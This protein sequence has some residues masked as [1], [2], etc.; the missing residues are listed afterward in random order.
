MV[1]DQ[2]DRVLVTGAGQ[3]VGRSIAEAFLA[4]GAKVHFCDRDAKLVAVVLKANPGLS[5]SVTDVSDPASVDALF[6]DVNR[7]LGGVDVLVNIV[8][9]SGPRGRIDEISIDEWRQT[10]V[11]NVDSMFFCIRKAVPG[12]RSRKRGVIVNF[13]SASTRTAMPFRS[14][15]VTSKAAVEGLTR[16]LARELGPDGITVNAILPGMIDN[17]RLDFILSRIA[18]D[19]GRSKAEVEREML[20]FVSTRSKIQ[21]DEIAT[22]VVF[23]ASDAAKNISGQMMGVCGN[24]E[25][26]M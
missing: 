21:P 2:I 10:M 8:G 6:V 15:Y 17:A 4:S 26:E 20:G 3:S 9:I 24:I 22:T 5:G 25:W 23:L 11:S 16:T 13:S 19:E 7:T 14:P 18:Q 12:M 1:T